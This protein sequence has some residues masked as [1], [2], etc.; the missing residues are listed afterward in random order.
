VGSRPRVPIEQ[1]FWEKVDRRSYD[2]CWPWT[3]GTYPGG[4][5]KFKIVKGDLGQQTTEGVGA[6]RV[7]FRLIHGRWPTPNALHGCDNRVCCNAENP[8]HIHEG[9]Q[10]QNLEEM[11]ARGRRSRGAAQATNSSGPGN[12]WARHKRK[13]QEMEIRAG[14]IGRT[15]KKRELEP[16]PETA[17]LEEPVI[18]PAIPAPAPEPVPEPVPEPEPEKV[19]A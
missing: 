16:L 6:H 8:L 4:Y 9:T 2:E 7:A 17:P 1:R 10:Q 5:G 14:D 12:A 13:V 3:K 15:T 18:A 19:P 11:D